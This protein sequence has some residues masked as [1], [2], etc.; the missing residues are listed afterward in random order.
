MINRFASIQVMSRN[1]K[2]MTLADLREFVRECDE[3]GM[4]ENTE[5]QLVG[6]R[7]AEALKA[8]IHANPTVEQLPRSVFR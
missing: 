3:A 5:I 8:T 2:E 1:T 6:S 7:G 4:Y